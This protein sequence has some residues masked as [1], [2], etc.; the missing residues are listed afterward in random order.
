MSPALGPRSGPAVSIPSPVVGGPLSGWY[1]SPLSPAAGSSGN[2][3]MANV[4]RL[5]TAAVPAISITKVGLNITA[6]ADT[7]CNFT[8]AIYTD[9]NGLPD[10]LVAQSEPIDMTTLADGWPFTTFV[11]QPVVSLDAGYYWYGGVLQGTFATQ[12]TFVGIG[13][14]TV[15]PAAI[16]AG[17]VLDG[18]FVPHGYGFTGQSGPLPQS[19][20]GETFVASTTV[21]PRLVFVLA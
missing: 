15:V 14:S 7:D 3:Y 12:P 16:L 8:A 17:G 10:Q 20:Q 5:S 11:D 9:L 19:L 1:W 18:G 4:L 2:G 21:E 6:V 13:G